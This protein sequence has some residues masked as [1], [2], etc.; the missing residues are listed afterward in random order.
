MTVYTDAGAA[1]S[2]ASQKLIAVLPLFPSNLSRTA[3]RCGEQLRSLKI[4]TWVE[5]F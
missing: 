1:V 4:L 3:S 5:D 2:S